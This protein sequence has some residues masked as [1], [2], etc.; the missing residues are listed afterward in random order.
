MTNVM[1]GERPDHECAIFDH[2]YSV[3][4]YAVAHTIAAYRISSLVPEF[5]LKPENV[6]DKFVAA[7][8]GTD[9]DFP[10]HP[11]FSS[12]YRLV[13]SDQDEGVIRKMFSR[14]LCSLFE[15]EQG[16]T[17]GGK[18]NWVGMYKHRILVE[19]H[20]LSAFYEK[21]KG[22][23]KAIESAARSVEC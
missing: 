11:T 2:R 1:R 5:Q 3:D 20:K 12:A 16:W 9:V 4:E 8:G 17:I 14:S 13:C 6:L 15:R 21:N 19:S 7:F 23:A 22:I 10:N 18:G